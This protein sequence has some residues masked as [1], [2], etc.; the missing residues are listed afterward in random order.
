MDFHRRA[1]RWNTNLSQVIEI[2]LVAKYVLFLLV[3]AILVGLIWLRGPFYGRRM[4]GYAIGIAEQLWFLSGQLLAG[5]DPVR[6]GR[7]KAVWT[8]RSVA[9]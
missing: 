9:S 2:K 8:K 4:V 1:V 3:C 7:I 5:L 6:L